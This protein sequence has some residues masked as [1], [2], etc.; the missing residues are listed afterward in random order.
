LTGLKN[1]RTLHAG[2]TKVTKEGAAALKK[3]L[4]NVFVLAGKD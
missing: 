2:G 1:L 3:S 4:P